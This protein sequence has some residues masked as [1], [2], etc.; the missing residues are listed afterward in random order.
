MVRVLACL[1]ALFL[2]PL[3]TSA[4]VESGV[5]VGFNQGPPNAPPTRDARPA[6]GRSTIRGH[7]VAA[8]SGQPVRRATVRITAPE[9][10]VPRSMVTDANGQY[11][12]AQLPAGRYSINASKNVFVSWSYGQTQPASPG[13]PVVLADNQTVDNLNI[14]LP[15]GA[16]LTGRVTDEFGDPVPTVFV[17]LMRLQFVQ[18]QLRLM[19]AGNGNS[20][21]TNDLGEYRMF[22]LSPG[23]YYVAAQPQQQAFPVV[24][25]L[26]GQAEG[27]EA[28]N[29]YAR[30][31]YPG[32]AD[33]STAQKITVGLGQTLGEI[34]IMLLATRLA[35]ISGVAVNSQGQPFG[36][37]SVQVM[38]RGGIPFGGISGGPLRA[39]GTFTV[40]NVP[41]GQYTLRAIA[42]QAPP[43]P[44]ERPAPPEF[45]VAVVSVNGEDVTDVRLTPVVPVILSGRV[46]FDDPGAAQSLKPSAIRVMAQALNLDDSIG[47]PVAPGPPP[48]LQDDFSFELKINPG[49]IGL[50]TTVQAAPGTPNG[51]QVKAVR[52]N[53]ID[54]TDSGIEIDARGAAGIE[55]ELTNRRQEMSGVVTDA[56]GDPVKDYAVVLFAQDRARWSA[57]FNRYFA[58]GRAGDDGRFKVGTLPPGNY[59]AIA[60][61]R[62]DPAQSQDPEFLE[63]LT[64]QAST[65]SLTQGETRTLDL[66]L[67]TVQ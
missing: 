65:F 12:F 24:G 20:P 11:E 63:G 3:S 37:G 15:R 62:I 22:G 19:P 7:I 38:P 2:I 9:L 32:T 56:R 17:S 39:D 59:Y 14:S 36:R 34:N 41:P 13:R 61:D 57:P 4:Q 64:R 52:V 35:T 67:F 60:L 43:A 16:V 53:G 21:A 29:G 51:W 27:A 46:S 10:R 54:V 44:G 66:K 18:G 26:G 40:P 50:R 28:R 42:P 45:S 30:T 25:A 33:V 5:I 23:Q 1:T 48:A 31:F 49:R 47:F 55:I 8:D 6:T 58:T